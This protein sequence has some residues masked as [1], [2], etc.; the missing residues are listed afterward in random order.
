MEGSN[1]W[2]PME[3]EGEREAPFQLFSFPSINFT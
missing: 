1:A 2:W 3:G